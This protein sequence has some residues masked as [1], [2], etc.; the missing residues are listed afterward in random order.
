M[1]SLNTC[2]LNYLRLFS[3]KIN[4]IYYEKDSFN[5]SI[6]EG[7]YELQNKNFKFEKDRKKYAL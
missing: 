4:E 3:I 2:P 5:T 7:C 6:Y 1:L